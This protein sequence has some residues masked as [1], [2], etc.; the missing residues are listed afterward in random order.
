[1]Q[2]L[3][4]NGIF[5]SDMYR[6]VLSIEDWTNAFCRS[7]SS[8]HRANLDGTASEKVLDTGLSSC[9]MRCIAFDK[10]N[11]KLFFAKDND[12]SEAYIY[13]ANLDGTGIEQIIDANI[14]NCSFYNMELD[15]VNNFIYW[16]GSGS[17]IYKCSMDGGAPENI[18]TTTNPSI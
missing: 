11:N 2:I 1:M 15:L 9:Y 14:G 7:Y 10:K 12:G 18:H 6:W 4:W 8:I 3:Q 17:A 5:Y 13:S 16:C